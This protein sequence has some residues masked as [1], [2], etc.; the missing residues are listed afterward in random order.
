MH[1][2]LLSNPMWY[3]V[4]LCDTWSLAYALHPLW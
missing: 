1:L 3:V 2:A 4:F